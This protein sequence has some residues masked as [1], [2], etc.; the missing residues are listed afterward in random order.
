MLNQTHDSE[1]SAPHYS[2]TQ[3]ESVVYEVAHETI[4]YMFAIC[5]YLIYEER[6]KTNSKKLICNINSIPLTLFHSIPFINNNNKFNEKNIPN[7]VPD[8][9]TILDFIIALFIDYYLLTIFNFKP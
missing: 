3:E 6:N 7:K 2:W 8:I 4:G 1:V 5:S 9:N